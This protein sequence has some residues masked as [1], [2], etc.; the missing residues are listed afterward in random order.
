MHVKTVKTSSSSS[1]GKTAFAAALGFALIAL[2]G[3]A[4]AEALRI[5]TLPAADSIVLY[6]AQENGL[7]KKAGLDVEVIPFKSA[8]ELGAA[9]RAGRLDGHFG[10]LMN[11]FTQ[12][13]TGIPQKVILTTTHTHPEQRAFGLVASPKSAAAPKTLDELKAKKDVTTAMSSSTIV[14]YL[15]DRMT[16]EEKLAEGTLKNLE[17]KQIPI[18]MQ[19]LLGGKVDTALLP[20]PLV[21]VVESKGGKVLWDDRNLNEALAVVALKAEKLDPK[22]VESFRQATAEAARV[23]E[24]EPERY[25]AVMVKKGLLPAPV[26]DDYKMVAFSFFG[27]KDGL[28]PLPT[29]EEVKRVG[30]WMVG[31]GMLKA[32][33]AWD[34]VV[35]PAAK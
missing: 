23:I 30:D 7:F 16:G 32:A 19:M 9:M 8:L 35:M 25:R 22:T 10:D 12:N 24:A 4:A 20:E 31:Q 6:V 27:T 26:A 34:A 33:P 13:E 2:T 1:R 17:V 18:R 28:P 11:V 5:G 3:T 29:P 21:T 14:H 15:L